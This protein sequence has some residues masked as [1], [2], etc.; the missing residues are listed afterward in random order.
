MVGGCA[1]WTG[2]RTSRGYGKFRVNGRITLVHCWA[3]ETFVGAVPD[4]LE[5]DHLCRNRACTGV[6]ADGVVLGHLE[7]VT[8]R[9]NCHRGIGVMAINARKRGCPQ[10]HLYDTQNT[11]VWNGKR[12]CRACHRD[13]SRKR[14]TA[15]KT[16][17]AERVSA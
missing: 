5:L 17:Q 12:S 7:P 3:Y 16:R 10:G 13:R 11:Y 8:H 9:D 1:V 14:R 2:G 15:L 4:G 6:A